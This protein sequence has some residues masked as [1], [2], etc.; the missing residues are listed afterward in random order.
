[1]TQNVGP[2]GATSA[3][4]G[5]VDIGIGKTLIPVL[6]GV[7]LIGNVVENTTSFTKCALCVGQGW[8][9]YSSV[10]FYNLFGCIGI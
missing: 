1:M 4:K 3:G 10:R 8:L 7:V 9:L 2:V 6:D 5:I